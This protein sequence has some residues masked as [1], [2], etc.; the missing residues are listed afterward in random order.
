M[1]MHEEGCDAPCWAHL[2]DEE[3]GDVSC[4]E[5]GEMIATASDVADLPAIAASLSSSGTAWTLRSNDLNANLLV[6]NPGGR[7][8]EHV[9]ERLDV[10]IIGISGGG[11]V[12]IDGQPH[13]LGAGGAILAPKG[14]SRS[15]RALGE[16]FAYL[17]CH[18]KRGGLWPVSA[19]TR[20]TSR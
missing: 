12:T 8:P 13:N 9:N 5:S 6:L 14:S 3:T 7:S 16:P 20:A 19:K 2:F 18:Q 17:A 15:I 1:T 10:L 4:S 11:V